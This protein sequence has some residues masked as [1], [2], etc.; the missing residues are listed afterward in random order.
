MN[1]DGFYYV[2]PFINLFDIMIMFKVHNTSRNID[3]RINPELKI[4]ILLL[5]IS[6]NF[7]ER[8]SELFLHS[9]IVMDTI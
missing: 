1:G 7:V 6:K 3:A 2:A 5:N 9:L 4:V 8:P